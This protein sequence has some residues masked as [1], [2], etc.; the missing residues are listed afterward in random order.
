MIHGRSG[1]AP[2]HCTA[3]LPW[4]AV[5]LVWL[6]VAALMLMAGWGR[7]AP[8]YFLDGDDALRLQQVRDL[9]QGQGWFDLHQYRI[10]P[11][12]GVAMH[13]TR[14][15]DVPIAALILALRPLIGT[16]QAEVFA[17]VL[18]PLLCLLAAMAL[19]ARLAHRLF[20]ANAGAYAALLVAASFPASFR[21]MPLRIDHHAW[22]FVLALVA[23]NGLAARAPRSGGTVAGLALALAL[24]IS[25]ESLPLTVIF[26][27]VCALRLLRGDER[28]LCWFMGAL[29]VSAMALFALT[30]APGDL[31]DHCDALSPV[32]LMALGAVAA[33]CAAFLPRLR[34]SPPALGILVLGMCGVAAIAI[35]AARAPQCL[36]GDAFAALDPLVR[37]VWLHSVV[38][39]QPVW[40]QGVVLGATMVF[41]PLFGLVAC[42]RLWRDA[43]VPQARDF[44]MDMGLL[45]AGAT[46]IG[47]LVARA[48][49]VAC[50]FA[51]VPAAWQIGDQIARWSADR[52][53]WRRLGRVVLLVLL[54]LPGAVAGSISSV[55][56]PE[57][58]T[59]RSSTQACSMAALAPDLA[60]IPPARVMAG[61]DI[62]PSLLVTSHHD[63]LAT[64]HHR[65]SAAMR[66]LLVAFLG[67]DDGAHAIIARRHVGIVAICPTGSESRFYRKLAPDGFM[68]HLAAGRAPDW[69]VPVK[70]STGSGMK[71]WRVR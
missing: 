61:L 33:G 43:N 48:S 39:G 54:L 11:P 18:V 20:G 42:W 59:S 19:A 28:W 4:A 36:S 26:A 9:L 13:W 29:S 10:A 14:V 40:R 6:G 1:P 21:M 31:T 3:P 55:V 30:R 56:R 58:A 50:L 38:E 23:L 8:A 44:W 53:L 37:K 57:G 24:S 5:L 35:F 68:A 65:A 7:L 66:D 34:R 46:V 16:S 2:A 22:Q 67:P 47:L 27:G 12:E 60:R 15:V 71:V 64:A 49:A 70:V 32:H 69:L 63:V 25:L 17:I 62:G 51:A 52:L 41:L 45:L